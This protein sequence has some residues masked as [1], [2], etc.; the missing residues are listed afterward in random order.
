MARL[1]SARPKA[2]AVVIEEAAED[3]ATLKLRNIQDNSKQRF[4]AKGL[5]DTEG[6]TTTTFIPEQ[7]TKDFEVKVDAHSTSP[8][9]M[10]DHKNDA[11]TFLEA[12]AITRARFLKMY[13]APEEQILL[14]E[15]K[16]I[17][18]KEAEAAKVQMAMEQKQGA[19]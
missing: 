3:L 7:F 15:L 9:F 4:T 12:K 10:E 17:E 5:K 16:G 11:A 18:A 1:S 2:R 6:N 8:I 13:G 19:K 14:E